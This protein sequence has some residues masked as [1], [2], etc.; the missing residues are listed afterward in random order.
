MQFLSPAWLLGL[1]LPVVLAVLAGIHYRRHRQQWGSF[2][3]DP[4]LA[5]RLVQ[6]S[7][8][9][10]W[11]TTTVL[12]L[13][14]LILTIFALAKPINGSDTIEIPSKGKR[15]YLAIDLSRSMLVE[16]VAPNRLTK[17][18]TLGIEIIEALPQE[19]IGIISF[20]GKAWLEAPLTT[21]H[22]VLTEVLLSTNES[23]VPY[24]GSNSEQLF[25]MINTLSA[26]QKAATETLLV[27]LSDGEFHEEPAPSDLREA[28]ANGFTIY[29]VGVGTNAGGMVPDKESF[30]QLFRDR[31]GQLVNS[32]LNTQ[33]LE[34]IAILG[35]GESFLDSNYDFVP[36]LKRALSR[37]SGETVASKKLINYNHIYP[38]FLI[39]ALLCLFLAS[40]SSKIIKRMKIG[41]PS[42]GLFLILNLTTQPSEA[43]ELHASYQHAQELIEEEQYDQSLEEISALL[44]DSTG[45]N[46]NKL[47]F[48][49]GYAEYK[50]AEYAKALDSFSQSLLSDSPQLQAESHYN[51]GN[52]IYQKGVAKLET[53][54]KLKN[55]TEIIVLR[56]KVIKDWKESLGH[57]QGTLHLSADHP[58]AKENYEY[59]KSKLDELQKEQDELMDLLKQM[60]QGE[61]EQGSPGEGQ[62]ESPGEGDSDGDTW[63]E[64]KKKLDKESENKG[65]AESDDPESGIGNEHDPESD[66]DGLGGGSQDHSEAEQE[67]AR[68]MLEKNSDF[69]SGNLRTGRQRFSKPSKDW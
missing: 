13:L 55:I 69:E 1:I 44:L 63:E 50:K 68:E 10:A 29:T 14:G 34:K 40:I 7:S 28:R 5:S 39:P 62:S 66:N 42:L 37:L 58:T 64:L 23:S 41:L 36:R 56:D 26:D 12:L 8:P 9:L 11:W 61:G 17:A 67:Q 54:A 51:L 46:T 22:G 3:S 20:A 59:V 25:S 52:T 4:R 60:G 19:K 57:Y 33:T 18:K 35:G 43:A 65:G 45:E 32:S 24:G 47:H 16:D 21:D 15:V 49:K 2:V 30:D 38:Y 53:V 27:I 48:S 31:S 6:Q